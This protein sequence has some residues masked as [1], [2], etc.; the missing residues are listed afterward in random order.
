[1]QTTAEKVR[2]NAARRRAERQG[3][4]L[5][6]VRRRDPQSID[7]GRFRVLNPRTSAVVLGAP[8]GVVLADVE[9]WL[10][11]GPHVAE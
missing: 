4:K 10:D 9:R 11:A 6:K 1:M 5:E 2:E 8:F 3:V 7:Y